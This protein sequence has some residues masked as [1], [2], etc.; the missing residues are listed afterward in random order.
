[1]QFLK[2]AEKRLESNAG[3]GIRYGMKWRVVLASSAE[4]QF[5]RLPKSSVSR[6]S[7][8]FDAMEENP[9]DGDVAKL[10]GETSVWRRRIGE[11]RIIFEIVIPEKTVFVYAILRRTTTT[12]S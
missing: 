7:R 6:I 11:H 1:M 5:R 9:W 8:A 3:I 4:K 12:Y 10:E 2:D